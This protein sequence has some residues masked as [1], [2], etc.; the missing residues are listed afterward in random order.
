MRI[1][2]SATPFAV[3]EVMNSP[4]TSAKVFSFLLFIK[5]LFL[6]INM[7]ASLHDILGKRDAVKL[8]TLK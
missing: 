6:D 5:I 7:T 4:Q 3:W 2:I 8:F 1:V